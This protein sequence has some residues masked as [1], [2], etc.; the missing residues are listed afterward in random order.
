MIPIVSVDV[1]K[2]PSPPEAKSWA[3]K[4]LMRVATAAIKRA[5]PRIN[6]EAGAFLRPVVRRLMMTK[7]TKN[8]F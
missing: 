1:A 4:V 3:V 7:R 8:L 5:E 6:I 2:H